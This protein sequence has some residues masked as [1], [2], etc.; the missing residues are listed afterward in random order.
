LVTPCVLIPAGDLP[1]KNGLLAANEG[2]MLVK[3]YLAG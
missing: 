1:S 3:K 2:K